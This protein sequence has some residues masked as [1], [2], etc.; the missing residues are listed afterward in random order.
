MKARMILS[1]LMVSAIA[2]AALSG[3]GQAKSKTESSASEAAATETTVPESTVPETTVAEPVT[4]LPKTDM[5]KW[6]YSEENDLYYQI[7]ISYCEHPVDERY[8]KLAYFVPAPYMDATKNADDTYT[9]KLN[10][11]A[12]VSGSTAA[13]APIAL[14]VNTPSYYAAEAMTEDTVDMGINMGGI[15]DF[16]SMGMVY[17]Y[18]G[19]RGIDEGAPSG[20]TDLKAAIRY[21]RYCD[22][23][24]AGDAEKIFTF[25]LSGG[26]AQSV[27]LGAS[28][29]SEMYE[30]YLEAIGA[31]QGVSDSVLGSASWCPVTSLDTA[32]AEY[33]WMMGCTRE[34]RSPEENA[35]SDKL[36]EAFAKY[37][38]SAGFV[39]ENGNEL[40]LAESEEGIYQAGS[41]YDHV[42]GVIERS[43]NNYL[44]DLSDPQAAQGYVDDMNDGKKWIDYD[45]STNTATISSIADFARECKQAK[46]LTTGFDQPEGQ[47]NLFGYGDSKRAHFD[48]ILCDVLTELGSKY[49]ADYSEDLAK[50]DALGYSV[51]QRVN[52]YSPLYFLMESR[53]GYKTANVAKYWRIRSGIEQDTNSVTTEINLDLALKAFDGV[54]S[55]DFET[56]W[57]RNHDLAERDGGDGIENFIDWV[58]SCT[59]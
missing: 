21:L 45:K 54:E 18:P 19:C 34:G 35:M 23:V 42:K 16:T 12:E 8:Q 13:T 14:S 44:A 2:A 48:R 17:V 3:C 43:L 46:N 32:N 37:V 29:D 57:E 59:K 7:G 6:H 15:G 22:D 51:E 30:P 39:D 25:G 24:N 53:E 55:V 38:N 58:I 28:G 11:S 20:V 47:N 33:E 26:G 36:A 56:I 9:C 4:N 49:A 40:K 10:E 27:L 52:M 41:Y 50:K 5:T 31:V 1:A